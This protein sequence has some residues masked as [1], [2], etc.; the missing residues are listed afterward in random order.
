M[1]RLYPEQLALQLR[2]K[3]HACYLVIGNEPL[4]I[5]ESIN[6]I[7]QQAKQYAFTEYFSFLLDKYTDWEN[8]IN[9]FQERSLFANRQVIVLNMLENG[10]NTTI[11]AHL[12]KLIMLLHSDLLLIIYGDKLTKYQENTE[13]YKN[14]SRISKIIICNTPSQ[15]QLSYWVANRAKEMHINLDFAANQLICYCYEGNLLA[16]SQILKRFLLLYS[17]G[18]LTLDRMKKIIHYATHFSIFH[19][20]EAILSGNSNRALQILQQLYQ[21]DIEPIIILRVIQR[22]VLLL[23][24]FKNNMAHTELHHLFNKYKI[25]QSRRLLIMQALNSLSLKAIYQAIDL[26]SHLEIKLKL[27]YNKLIWSKLELLTLLLCG[28]SF[29]DSII[30]AISIN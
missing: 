17:D 11:N 9:L 8:I 15:N 5:Q 2:K 14:I 22:E 24:T 18:E 23:V 4:L 13:W 29:P 1:T 21:E 26:L 16:I 7:R 19:W 3:L 10:A 30:N 6:L 25:W 12:N 20:V 28:Q 27:D